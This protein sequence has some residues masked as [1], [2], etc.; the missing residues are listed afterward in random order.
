MVINSRKLTDSTDSAL[1]ADRSIG[2]FNG[3]GNNSRRVSERAFQSVIL[4]GRNADRK[5][6][7]EYMS[8]KNELN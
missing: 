4:G 7:F 1:S 2:S 6:S 5:E 3:E 8:I